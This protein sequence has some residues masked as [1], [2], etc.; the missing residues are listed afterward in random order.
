M[1]TKPPNTLLFSFLLLPFLH[2]VLRAETL[3]QK[4]DFNQHIRPILSD[5][6]FFCHGP[7]KAERKG[8]LR[9]DTAEGAKKNKAI[10]PENLSESEV[11]YRITTD[12]PD[13]LMPPAESHKTLTPHEIA[14]IKQWIGEGAPYDSQWIYK[15]PVKQN[16]PALPA[17]ANAKTHNAID[18][19]IQ[20]ELKE[21]QRV[22]AAAADRT[23][24][25]RRL[26]FD[27]TGLPPSPQEVKYFV[28]DQHPNAYQKL[29]SR[30]I[31]SP[32]FGE[33]M[34]AKWLD[35]VRYADT[36]GFHGD[37]NVSQSPYRDYV[38]KAFNQ[39]MRYDQ[40]T[41]EQ[42]AGD[43]LPNPTLDQKVASGYNRLNMT[44]E[45]GG[46]QPKEYLAKYAGDRVRNTSVVFLG[47]TIGCAECHD[48]K[49]DPYTAE[50]FYTFAAFFA[51]LQEVGKYGARK[52]P[53]E[54]QVPSE[55][56]QQ[57]I[58]QLE[59]TITQLKN[60]L[61][62]DTPELAA[63]QKEWAA[64]E[65]ARLRNLPALESTDLYFIEDKA[66]AGDKPR[67]QWN[68]AAKKDSPTYRGAFSRKQES[69]DLV[70]HILDF[71][72]AYQPNPQDH[73]FGYI[74]LDPKNPPKT[75]MLQ[76][77][78]NKNW[79]HRAY[80]GEDKIPYGIGKNGPHHLHMGPLPEAGKWVR[81]EVSANKIGVDEKQPVTGIAFTQFGGRAWWD[82]AGVNGAH[83][84][85]GMPGNI[86]KNLL[87]EQP[88]EDEVKQ[89][90]TY[91][92]NISPLLN[93]AREQL[94]K[95]EQALKSYREKIPTMPI[96]ISTKP[97]EIRVL[98]RGNWMD[99]SGPIVQP[100]IPS[101]LGKLEPT[102]G[103]D[104]LTRLDLANW[105]TSRENPMA[106]RVFVNHLWS[107]FFGAGISNVLSDLGNQG[108]PP[109]HPE[110]LDWLAVEFMDS[111][112]DIKHM[113]TLIT[114]SHT[115]R[116]TSMPPA[117]LNDF[118]PYN[119]L[120]SCQSRRRLSAEMVRDNALKVSGLLNHTIGGPSV[121]P[122]QPEGYYAQLNFPRRTYKHSTDANQYRRAVYSHWQRTFLHP[123][124]MA[125]DA[126]AR[127]ACTAQRPVS[128][129]PLQAL[130]LM[131]DPSFVEAA[132]QLA[133]RMDQEGGKTIEQRVT[134]AYNEV[135]N[136]DPRSE[137]VVVLKNIYEKHLSEYQQHPEEAMALL[138]TGLAPLE[139]KSAPELAAWTSVS[140]I[141][142]NLHES[143]TRF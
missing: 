143:I 8:K 75:V 32:T 63:A 96:S 99:E 130:V 115:Y 103:Q 86:A 73:F 3:P 18:Q 138:S 21:H 1:M 81:L 110:L 37:Q 58:A 111:G 93:S 53:P 116:Q 102:N 108:E 114:Q 107:L 90:A 38:I 83:A 26:S 89:L 34:A 91:Y 36:V 136:R 112:W 85:L 11:V 87:N 30:L 84:S 64:Q 128:N 19:F 79:N 120:L 94:G 27:L 88:T 60:A 41:R 31:A 141:L 66:K 82:D 50:D 59:D 67:E 123:A 57:H 52:R 6:C 131:N 101:F 72:E 43:L 113:I 24:L 40:F 48:H 77:Y 70:Q 134:W 42:L 5:K 15:K 140:R 97:R 46:A 119:R 20:A 129:T 69:K 12:D 122:Y 125:F 14:L 56:D 98:H 23:T 117:D 61:L 139:T 39:N 62:T 106:A 92:R 74:Y 133:H 100:A 135:L 35:L 104:R 47:A 95:T 22:P 33:R 17:G 2:P 118:D 54:I 109:Q 137:E 45:E 44:T 49:Y 142:L 9:L 127:E 132:K 16:P 71:K 68:Y 121:H 78:A 13:D 65:A 126:P 4:V 80:W 76:I 28:S 10:V 105:I 29:V 51:D 55:Q 124:M 25:I 7:D